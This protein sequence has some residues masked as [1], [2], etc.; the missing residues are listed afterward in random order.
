[1]RERESGRAKCRRSRKKKKNSQSKLF[2]LQCGLRREI[3]R[4]VGESEGKR[5]HL[6]YLMVWLIIKQTNKTKKTNKLLFLYW[7]RLH[8]V[9]FLTHTPL[10]CI[11]HMCTYSMLMFIFGSLSHKRKILWEI[12]SHFVKGDNPTVS[13]IS[14]QST[15]VFYFSVG[16]NLFDL[17]WHWLIVFWSDHFVML[18]GENSSKQERNSLEIIN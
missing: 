9:I 16:L 8:L 1:M 18:I 17:L 3:E 2:A 4:R 6:L 12:F 13:L 7:R 11:C 5:L 10:D 15:T 14:Q